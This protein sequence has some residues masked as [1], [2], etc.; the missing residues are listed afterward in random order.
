MQA[1]VSISH[2]KYDIIVL[3]SMQVSQNMTAFQTT[4]GLN[5][6]VAVMIIHIIRLLKINKRSCQ[7]CTLLVPKITSR[8][9]L[10]VLRKHE[11]NTWLYITETNCDKCIYQSNRIR[12]SMIDYQHAF[13][14]TLLFTLI[15]PR[16]CFIY[17]YESLEGK[18]IRIDIQVT[19]QCRIASKLCWK[20][21]WIKGYNIHFLS[22]ISEYWLISS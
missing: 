14:P 22:I 20:L 17:D 8:I 3:S 4:Y 12:L 6:A 16:I 2:I 5:V 11:L 18:N 19:F 10:T 15:T 13:Y 1:L 9:G 21:L 7:T